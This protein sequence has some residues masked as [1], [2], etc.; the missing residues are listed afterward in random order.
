MANINTYTAVGN[1]EDLSDIITNI[2][3]KET[4]IFSM[5]GKEKATGTYHEWLE[6]HH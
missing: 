6:Y 4:P 2:A 5:F 1:R 3:V